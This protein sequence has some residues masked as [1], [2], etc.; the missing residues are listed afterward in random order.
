M[1]Y[2]LSQYNEHGYDMQQLKGLIP[3]A[4]AEHPQ[5]ERS[6][7]YQYIPTSTI[8]Q[9]LFDEGFKAVSASQVIA[10]KPE[11][12]GFEKHL[13]RLQ[14]S[15]HVNNSDDVNQVI[16]INSHNGSSCYELLSGCFRFACANGLII[17]NADHAIKVKHI[18]DYTNDVIE[19]TF[20]VLDQ[21]EELEHSKNTLKA[22]T[23][24][25]YEKLTYAESALVMRY[26]DDQSPLTPGQLIQPS[27]WEDNDNSL[28][29]TYNRVQEKMIRGGL[30]GR[31]VD[32]NGRTKIRRT[33]AVNN[34]TQSVAINKGL[35]HL[36]LKMGEMIQAAA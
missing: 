12:R 33:R 26:G 3:A 19:G 16:L 6:E 9:R 2:R 21:F 8:L 36:A 14:H 4:F 5:Q 28:W 13:V 15:N 24:D 17:G 34:I 30:Q 20:R 23:L 11:Q 22:I 29:T 7:R 32:S 25:E 10:R 31:T 35:S 27:R 1:S 18:G